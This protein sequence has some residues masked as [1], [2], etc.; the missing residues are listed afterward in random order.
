MTSA[1]VGA[2][3]KDIVH[4]PGR[5]R[6]SDHDNDDCDGNSNSNRANTNAGC[7]TTKDGNSAAQGASRPEQRLLSARGRFDA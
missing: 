3:L 7:S 6:S 4:R 1:T 5:R 2:K